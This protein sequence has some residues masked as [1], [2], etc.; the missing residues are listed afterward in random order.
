MKNSAS[1]GKRTPS[2]QNKNTSNTGNNGTHTGLY[3]NTK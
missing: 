1:K 2:N 3:I